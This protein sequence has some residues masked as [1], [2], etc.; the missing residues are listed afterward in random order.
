[1]VSAP[2]CSLKLCSQTNAEKT[3]NVD[4]GQLVTEIDQIYFFKCVKPEDLEDVANGA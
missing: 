1:M 3:I 2:V 4:W